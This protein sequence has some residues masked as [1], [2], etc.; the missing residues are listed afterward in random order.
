MLQSIVIMSVEVN[1]ITVLK[2][3]CCLF[4][5]LL[6]GA[7]AK[8]RNVTISFVMSVRSSVCT[9]QLSFHWTN[10]HEIL[11]ISIF[12]KSVKNIQVSLKSDKNIQVS[13]KSDK[14]NGTLHQDK[15]TFFYH[16]SL[17]SSPNENCFRHNL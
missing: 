11:N 6:L 16:I 2:Y 8:L 5:R 12:R 1:F 7:F 3:C 13:L 17:I 4:F 9:E 10:F 15:Y 14:N